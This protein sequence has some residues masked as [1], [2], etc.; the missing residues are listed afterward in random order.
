MTITNTEGLS[1]ATLRLMRDKLGEPSPDL[2]VSFRTDELDSIFTELLSRRA[3]NSAGGVEVKALE[4]E[5]YGVRPW[6]FAS[7]YYFIGKQTG[8][9][10]YWAHHRIAGDLRGSDGKIALHRSAEEA[11]AAAQ[12]DFN[13]RILSAIVFAVE[14]EPAA[15]VAPDAEKNPAR[16]INRLVEPEVPASVLKAFEDKYRKNF[17]LTRFDLENKWGNTTRYE[18]HGIQL[19]WEGWRDGYLALHPSSPVSAE[20]TVTDEM[21]EAGCRAWMKSDGHTAAEI[22]RAA[23]AAAWEAST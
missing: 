10:R 23:L 20:V 2:A 13:Q 11:K 9:G 3:A 16:W 18:H 7:P 21:V 5:P 14:A 17:D 12:A 8:D 1:D 6:V 4:W 19:L 15:D 22:M